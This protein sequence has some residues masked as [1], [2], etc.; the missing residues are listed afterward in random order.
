MAQRVQQ[1]KLGKTISG[2]PGF[3]TSGFLALP[4]DWDVYQGCLGS[5]D[6][7]NDTAKRY[8]FQLVGQINAPKG[9]QTWQQQRL[10]SEVTRMINEA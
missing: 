8:G 6:Y 9:L 4:L 2:I 5:E 7:A 1:V 3:F 10:D